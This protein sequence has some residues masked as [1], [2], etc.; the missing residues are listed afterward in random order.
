VWTVQDSGGTSNGGVDTLT[1]SLAVSVGA[2]NDPPVRTAG[3]LTPVSVNEDSASTATS[4]GLTGVT[5]GPGGGSDEA[6]QTLQ[7]KVTALPSF[8]TLFKA[9]GTTSVTL[10]STLTPAELAGLKYK[11]VTDANGTGNLTWTVQDSGG[12]ANG[13]IDTITETLSITV[14]PIND[15][16]AQTGSI[17][18]VSVNEDLADATAASLGLGTVDYNPGGGS[19]EAGQSL[20]VKIT[21]IPSFITLFKSGGAAVSLNDT[22]TVAEL[23]QLTYKT[24]ANAN[25]TGN[26]V[27]TVQDSGGTASGGVDT[28]TGSLSVTVGAVNDA[29]V[30]SGTIT[31]ITVSEDFANTTA[32]S[33]GL[34]GLT[35]G[36]GGG[37]DESS[38]ATAQTLTVKVTHI[39]TFI[40]VF[41]GATQVQIN[42]TLTPAEL[43]Q[44][45]FKTVA[46]ASG[47]D[48]FI[49]TVQDNGGTA[50]GGVDSVSETLAI[51][52]LP[53]ADTPTVTNTATTENVQT[54][55]GLVITPNAADGG[56][57]TSFKITNVTNGTLFLNNG[58]TQVHDGDFITVTAAGAGLKFTPTNNFTGTG[59]FQAQASLTSDGTGLGGSVVT[60]NVIV[61]HTTA[62]TDAVTDEDTQSS[63]GLVITANAADTAVTNFQITTISHGTLFLSDGTTQV[64]DGDFITA[65]QGAAGLKFTPAA[66]YFGDATFHVQAATGNVAADLITGSV[67]LATIEVDPVADTP[68]VTSASTTVDTQTTSGLVI[69]PNA[70]DGTGVASFQITNITNGTLFLNDGTTQVNEGDFVTAAH[71]AAGLKFTPSSGFTGIGSFQA[72]ASLT[73]DATGL[74]GN[75]VTANITVV[76]TPSVTDTTTDEDTQSSSGLVITENV[77][78]T[79]VTHFQITGIGHGTLFLA[80]GTTQVHDGDFITVAQGAAGLKFTPA[81]D[82]FGNAA[83]QVQAATGNTAAGLISGATTSAS[84]EVDPVADTPSATNATTTVNTQTTSGLVITPNAA[85]AG[86]VMSFQITNI[87]NG[88]LFLNDGTTQVNEGDFITTAQA[89]AGLKFTPDNNFT[90]TG[91]FDVQASLTAD[92]TGLG[93][94]TKTASITVNPE[95]EGEGAPGVNDMAL[96]SFLSGDENTLEV[97]SASYP[98][99]VDQLMGQIL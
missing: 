92:A 30:Q 47:T 22:L 20:T 13:G 6:S 94:N 53:V 56:A 69:T 33:L 55:G 62:V 14:N 83:F 21:N 67:I 16:P 90:G 84:I 98:T 59:S 78:D 27:W 88:T 44:L 61:I 77:A 58:T 35:Y 34:T 41:N 79:V 12:T 38:G 72:Q 96:M 24:L 7:V 4:L 74:G 49:W 1:E 15:T 43:A 73:G 85:D 10:N 63:A 45:T 86:G 36:V 39:P 32:S 97:P 82:Y 9:D 99:A 87:T 28:L 51:T 37:S 64:H 25:G 66:D 71:A 26:L 60:A 8:I 29:P 18:P 11:T 40:H 57:I 3:S 68:A 48:N 19:D 17:A 95:G 75:V 76:H 89:G 31:P 93:G 50:S 5:Y 70:A 65:A 52:V 46:D 80:N 42:D 23:K 81:A 54:S 91:S 2:V